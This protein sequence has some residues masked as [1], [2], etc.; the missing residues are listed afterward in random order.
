MTAL[1]K[2][3]P[4]PARA[5]AAAPRTPPTKDMTKRRADYG[6]PV[7]SFFARQSP[8]LREVLDSLR[9]IV[10]KAVPDASAALKWGMPVYAVAGRNFVSLGGHKAHVNLV[11]WGEPG[12][13]SDP[14]GR[15][16]GDGPSG[17]ILRLT[18]VRDLPTADVRRWVKA[19]ADQAR[20]KA[21]KPRK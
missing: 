1:K 19:A 17:R 11:L 4:R 16:V 14:R 12:T 20:A 21:A 15:L 2:K 18:D 13:F 8:P 6:A 7:D 10:E 5:K 3:T 9:E